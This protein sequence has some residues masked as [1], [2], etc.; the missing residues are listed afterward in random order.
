LRLTDIVV[1][2]LPKP[3]RGNRIFYD[4]L[5]VGFGC[6]V[7]AAGHKAFTL[8][9]RRRVDGRQR[10]YTIGSVSHWSTATARE[11]ARRLKRRIDSGGDPIGELEAGRAAATTVADLCQRF[12]KE[13]LP[14]NRASTQRDYRQQIAAD[15]LPVLG[16]MKVTAVTHA[17]VD[18]LHRKIS[19]RAPVHA[20]RVIALLSRLFSL[21]VRWGLRGDNPCKGIDRNQEEKRQRYLSAAELARLST[22]LANLRD[23]GA[24]NAVR[25]LLLTG[26]RRGEVLAACWADFDL[27]AKVWT[28]PGATTKQK[29]LHRVPLSEA[30][31]GLLTEMRSRAEDSKWLF[32]ARFKPH[33]REIEDAWNSLRKAANIPDVR[34][35]DLRHTYA[36]VLV[37]AGLSLPVIGALLGHTTP[38][39][40]HRYA[41]LFDDPLRAA[42]ERAAAVI[43][44]KGKQQ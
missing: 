11:E 17:D 29:T 27:D 34:L 13:V 18:K 28:K 6:R 40:T 39:T 2:R 32:P 9:Y 15:L 44:G 10:R 38:T 23:Q 3:E 37:S 5:V 8:T 1:K 22:A 19:K 33:R 35:H 14:R 41:H 24:A 12:E 4:D 36:S 16:E 21:A 25:L 20:N 26:A 42:T 31:C 43:T 7:T 30:A